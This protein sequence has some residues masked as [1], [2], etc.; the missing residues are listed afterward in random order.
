[1]LYNYARTCSSSHITNYTTATTSPKWSPL[2]ASRRFSS[3]PS[4]Y[5]SFSLPPA[6]CATWHSAERRR[7]RTGGVAC[8]AGHV[9]SWPLTRLEVIVKSSDSGSKAKIENRF[10]SFQLG[11]WAT[12][13][14]DAGPNMSRLK[15]SH[16]VNRLCCCYC[17]LEEPPAWYCISFCAA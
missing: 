5:L 9:H 12:G 1:M 14:D 3:V 10:S 17:F 4:L 11:G 6:A 15:A 16:I 2:H 7:R 13:S 8:C